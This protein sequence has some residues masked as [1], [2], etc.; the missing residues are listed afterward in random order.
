M[1]GN[2][3]QAAKSGWRLAL[4]RWCYSRS[5]FNQLGLMRDDT[6]HET[7][8]VKEALK[9]LP[10][11]VWDRRVFRIARAIELSNRKEVLPKEEWT[12]YDTDDRYLGKYIDQV[13]NEHK[14][15]SEWAAK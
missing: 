10:P 3:A 7:E 1:G 9:R 8:V 11:D 2:M 15:R 5:Y 6:V 12:S 13:Q 4:A 14:E